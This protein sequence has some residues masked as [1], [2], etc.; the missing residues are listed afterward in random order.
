VLA[1]HQSD[2]VAWREFCESHPELVATRVLAPGRIT[3]YE[4]DRLYRECSALVAPS[5]YESFG[6]MYVE[7]FARCKPVIGCRAGGIPEVVREGETGFLVAP[8]SVDELIAAM[9]RLAESPGLRREMGRRARSDFESRFSDR[10]MAERSIALY[11][12]HVGPPVEE[13]ELP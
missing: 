12:Q 13:V 8:G 1:G 3:E 2:G 7:A 5:R 11:Q 9:V 10:M 6:L 4:L